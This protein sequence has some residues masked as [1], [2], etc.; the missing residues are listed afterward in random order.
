MEKHIFSCNNEGK[1]LKTDPGCSKSETTFEKISGRLANLN[2]QRPLI[3]IIETEPE[4]NLSPK[5]EAKSHVFGPILKFHSNQISINK[6]L[7]KRINYDCKPIESTDKD[8]GKLSGY[9]HYNTD[10]IPDETEVYVKT[11]LL[12][13]Q[14]DD[15]DQG[16][17]LSLVNINVSVLY[18][19]DNNDQTSNSKEECNYTEKSCTLEYSI[20]SKGEAI[21]NFFNNS[22]SSKTSNKENSSNTHQTPSGTNS[23]SNNSGGHSLSCENQKF[24][25]ERIKKIMKNKNHY[26]RNQK[27]RVAP[28]GMAASSDL[29]HCNQDP[30]EIDEL[31]DTVDPSNFNKKFKVAHSQVLIKNNLVALSKA[32]SKF[33]QFIIRRRVSF[34]LKQKIQKCL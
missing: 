9:D 10:D 21:P 8:Q 13:K 5:I 20:D 15:Q 30:E 4:V 22:K 16:D 18:S 3:N 25:Q 32:K 6:R 26:E 12:K 24:V 31:Y 1:R 2:T 23:N 34:V 29:P 33:N 27:L 19:S 7:H 17:D 14:E 11:I 28:S